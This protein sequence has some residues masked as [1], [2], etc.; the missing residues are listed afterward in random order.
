MSVEV[1]TIMEGKVTGIQ[2]FGCFVEL[3][4]GESGLVHI[5]EIAGEYVKNVEDHVKVGQ[6][7]KVKVLSVNE[8]GKISLSLKQAAEPRAPK[9]PKEKVKPKAEPLVL[10]DYE[11]QPRGA[12]QEESSF[13]DLMKR[14]KQDSDEKMQSLKNNEGRSKG[15][16][17]SSNS[18]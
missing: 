16:R 11:W 12:S 13:E 7:V 4:D 18:Y 9:P 3:S 10:S 17:R 8:K 15:Y 6:K 5:S 14:F 2:P 1:G